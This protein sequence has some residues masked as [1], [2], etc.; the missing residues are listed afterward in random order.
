M[1]IGIYKRIKPTWNKGIKIDMSKY[2]NYGM[3]GKQS[4]NKGLTYKINPKKKIGEMVSCYMCSKDFYVMPH[5]KKQKKT[6][7]KECFKTMGT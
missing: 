3:K 7:S 2:P 5:L 1:P 4:W 6:C